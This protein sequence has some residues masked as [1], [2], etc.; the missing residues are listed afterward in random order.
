MRTRVHVLVALMAL[1]S[2]AGCQGANA[3]S[4]VEDRNDDRVS[5]EITQEPEGTDEH[6][7]SDQGEVSEVPLSNNERLYLTGDEDAEIQH[8]AAVQL[9]DYLLDS[10]TKIQSQ[11]FAMDVVFKAGYIGYEDE[12]EITVDNQAQLEKASLTC[13]EHQEYLKGYS[14]PL[15]PTHREQLDELEG[16]IAE[17]LYEACSYG[18]ALSDGTVEMNEETITFYMD[19]IEN[20]RTRFDSLIS[21]LEDRALE[22]Q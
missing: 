5:E 7:S 11:L 17:R 16:D 22:L 6:D 19:M 12:G 2:L 15:T 8:N 9:I 20:L 14:G 1:V 21:N 10:T 4:E 3:D 13:L 18:F